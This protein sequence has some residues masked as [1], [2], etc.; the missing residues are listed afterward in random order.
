MLSDATDVFKKVSCHSLLNFLPAGLV[1]KIVR[2]FNP[3]SPSFARRK[4]D[5]SCRRLV[6]IL[7]PHRQMTTQSMLR[8]Q[9]HLSVLWYP[10]T[11]PWKL[12]VLSLSPADVDVLPTS[13]P[14]GGASDVAPVSDGVPGVSAE[15]VNVAT[16]NSLEPTISTEKAITPSGSDEAAN[17]AIA[18]PVPSIEVTR[19]DNQHASSSVAFSPHVNS[20]IEP[21]D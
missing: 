1:E 9:V 10:R 6:R 14:T 15:K 8:R 3:Q 16:S 20:D 18:L 17:A 7:Q 5:Q 12:T 21:G 2:K 13:K 11:C 4:V 19:L